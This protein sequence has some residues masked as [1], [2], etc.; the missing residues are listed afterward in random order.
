[1]NKINAEILVEG[2]VDY[3]DN[4]VVKSV[5]DR[6]LKITTKT[7]VISAT[8]NKAAYINLVNDSVTT[9]FVSELLKTDEDGYFEIEDVIDAIRQAINDCGELV[10]K[11]PAIKFLSPEE[12]IL[13]FTAS[14]ISSLKQYITN[15]ANNHGGNH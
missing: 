3:I 10:I 11:I 14:D 9:G 1:M 12:K 15:A 4:N 8:K 2:I 13:S 7:I 5:E 6:F